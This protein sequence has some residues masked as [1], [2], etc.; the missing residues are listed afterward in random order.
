MR[1]SC[2]DNLWKRKLDGMSFP[3]TQGSSHTS[4]FRPT[5]WQVIDL[6]NESTQGYALFMIPQGKGP[7][8]EERV[9]HEPPGL[10]ETCS[11]APPNHF[12]S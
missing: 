9:L 4:I 2:R 5:E 1:G 12:G 6:R 11:L 10:E 8:K 7:S 3:I